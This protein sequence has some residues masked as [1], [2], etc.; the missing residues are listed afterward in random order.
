MKLEKLRVVWIKPTSEQVIF[1]EYV[2]MV[3]ESEFC[4]TS[5]LKPKNPE[6]LLNHSDLKQKFLKRAPD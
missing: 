4:S 5:F 3:T 1:T 2:T 6:F